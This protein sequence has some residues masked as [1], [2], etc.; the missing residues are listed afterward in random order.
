MIVSL[1][2]AA[3]E[4]RR[5]GFPKL[6]LEYQGY[7]LLEGA[8]RKTK[9]VTDDVLVIVGAYADLYKPVAQ[10][11]GARVLTNLAWSEGLASSLRLGVTNCNA[12]AVL[13]VLPDQPFVTQAHLQALV[14]RQQETGASLV[15]SRYQDALGAET[16]GAP[17]VIDRRCFARV[18]ELKG[19]KGARALIDDETQIADVALSEFTDIDTPSEVATF[20][21]KVNT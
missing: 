17:C 7:S 14:T 6:T 1:I 20:L 15:F 18:L 12:D 3:G 8:I 9:A 16:L 5:M 4:S 13:V 19:D 21:G 2:L 11:A 10:Q